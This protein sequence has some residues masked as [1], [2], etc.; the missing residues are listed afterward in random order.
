ML[1]LAAMKVHAELSKCY[2][3]FPELSQIHVTDPEFSHTE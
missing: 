1:R 2:F 3:S